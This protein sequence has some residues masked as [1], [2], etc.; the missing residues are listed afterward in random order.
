MGASAM[1][2]LKIT[3]DDLKILF[4]VTSKENVDDSIYLYGTSKYNIDKLKI[5]TDTITFYI[6][7]KIIKYPYN[8]PD[9]QKVLKESVLY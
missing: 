3:I 7:N 4:N 5:D 9:L 8:N 1:F 2:T 6:D